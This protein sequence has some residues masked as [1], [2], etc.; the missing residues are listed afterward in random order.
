M[1]L[2]FRTSLDH[3]VSVITCC[4]DFWECASQIELASPSNFESKCCGVHMSSGLKDIWTGLDAFFV[5]EERGKE[6]LWDWYFCIFCILVGY[7]WISPEGKTCPPSWWKCGERLFLSSWIDCSI[8]FLNRRQLRKQMSYSMCVY[9]LT[10]VISY[11][12]RR[13]SKNA[14]N[15]TVMYSVLWTQHVH[16][17]PGSASHLNMVTSSRDLL[18]A[19]FP[20]WERG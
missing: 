19:S 6:W 20:G 18:L 16:S 8:N 9:T 13:H 17:D 14:K 12:C 15:W 2:G 10:Y 3:G 7:D 4:T 5:R 1:C 11:R